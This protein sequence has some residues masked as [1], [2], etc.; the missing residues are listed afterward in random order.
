MFKIKI[1][2]IFF[3]TLVFS[4]RRD[5]RYV[6]SLISIGWILICENL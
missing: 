4:A 2:M 5:G 1:P 3:G 6:F